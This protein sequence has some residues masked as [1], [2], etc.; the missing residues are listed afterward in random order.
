MQRSLAELHF[1]YSNRSA[2]GVEDA[3]RTE[4]AIKGAVG[5]RLTYR[6]THSEASEAGSARADRL[7]ARHLLGARTMRFGA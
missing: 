4:R 5:N 2:L 3:E 1:R 7:A 6:R